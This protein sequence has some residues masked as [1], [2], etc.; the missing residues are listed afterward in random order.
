MARHSYHSYWSREIA[1]AVL[2]SKVNRRVTV[3]Q[4]SE[5][6]YIMPEDIVSTLLRMGVVGTTRRDGSKVVAKEAVRE[7]L[8]RSKTDTRSSIEQAGW[9][10]PEEI[11]ESKRA[12]SRATE[13]EV[14]GDK[15]DNGVDGTDEEHEDVEGESDAMDKD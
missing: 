11:M 7:W 2:H 14:D 10:S 4:I 15:G 1:R 13:K 12:R 6:T 3:T 8:R 9:L 5:D